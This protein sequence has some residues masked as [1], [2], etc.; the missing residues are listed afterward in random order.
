MIQDSWTRNME[1]KRINA[2]LKRVKPNEQKVLNALKFFDKESKTKK[3]LNFNAWKYVCYY[4]MNELI[5][6]P[7]NENRSRMAIAMNFVSGP[8][9]SK[10]ARQM[11]IEVKQSDDP[12]PKARMIC[13]HYVFIKKKMYRMR[14]ILKK[15]KK[16]KKKKK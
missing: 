1:Y 8:L 2:F 16:K 11:N 3:Q 13:E 5:D 10:W 6:K 4:K 14:E 12:K 15:T 9:Y 7:G